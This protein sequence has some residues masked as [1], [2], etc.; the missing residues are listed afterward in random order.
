MAKKGTTPK[1]AAAK[2][3]DS[4]KAAPKKAAKTKTAAEKAAA[5]RKANKEAKQAEITAKFKASI[6][7][8]AKQLK[9]AQDKRDQKFKGVAEIVKE[10]VKADVARKD[11][12]QAVLDAGFAE[13]SAR[14]T[15]SELFKAAG[16]IARVSTPT[17]PVK[18]PEE[19]EQ[20]EAKPRTAKEEELF[21]KEKVFAFILNLAGQ[22]SVKAQSFALAAFNRFKKL[23]AEVSKEAKEAA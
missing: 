20:A 8:E 1:T 3:A 23:N 4:T 12:V 22:D 16:I 14:N 21:R 13:S 11:I 7:A 19:V 9:G 6:T 5:T 15:V 10:A 18:T 2:S 17:A